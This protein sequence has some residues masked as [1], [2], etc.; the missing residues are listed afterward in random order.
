M[1]LSA[2]NY[3][4]RAAA[5]QVLRY[6]GGHIVNRGNLINTAAGDENGRV[7]LAALVAGTW[8]PEDIGRMVLHTVNQHD[9]DPIWMKNIN[10]V[11]LKHL[12]GEGLKVSKASEIVVTH[13]RG[14]EL[15][16]FSAGWDI[17]HEDGSCVTCHQKNGK[18]LRPSGFPPLMDADWVLGDPKVLAKILL[19]GL[20]GPIE[21][22]DWEYPGQVPMTP[23]E[24]ILNDEEMAAVMTYV[25]NAFGNRAS[26]ITAEFVAQVRAEVEASGKKGYYRAE[27]L[28]SASR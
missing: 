13:L 28:K 3:K 6:D 19:K 9:I 17:Y 24:N 15:E 27:E 11:A 14:K 1:A 2:K 20:I 12:T 5:V 25:R 23:Y 26:T 21:V 18:G 7:R 8:L 10:D 16:Q 4:I 22:N